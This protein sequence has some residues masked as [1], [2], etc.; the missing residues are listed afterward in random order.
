MEVVFLDK[1]V[2]ETIVL[3]VFFAKW[4]WGLWC[5][6]THATWQYSLLLHLHLH[7]SGLCHFQPWL[8]LVEFSQGSLVDFFYLSTSPKF[9]RLVYFQELKS[10]PPRPPQV[11]P[12]LTI[13]LKT[14]I[15]VFP[16]FWSTF[17]ARTDGC[18]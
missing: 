1:V 4:K 15:Q 18:S 7:K 17:Q 11:P 13:S 2:Q 9:V 16:S 14:L 8:T 10:S 3:T 5:G 6:L 12:L